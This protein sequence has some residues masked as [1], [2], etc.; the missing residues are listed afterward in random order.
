MQ[1]SFRVFLTC[2]LVAAGLLILGC[3]SAVNSEENGTEGEND[4]VSS[5]L[6]NLEGS[7]RLVASVPGH[8]ARVNDGFALYY[9]EDS[10]NKSILH[11]CT[12]SDGDGTADTYNREENTLKNAKIN[13]SDNLITF[14]TI[15]VAKGI[16]YTDENLGKEIETEYFD[17]RGEGGIFDV[18]STPQSG[19]LGMA[20]TE[21]TSGVPTSDADCQ[22]LDSFISSNRDTPSRRDMATT[23]RLNSSSSGF[24]ANNSDSY[25]LFYDI[26]SD[27]TILHSCT[28]SD[29]DDQADTYVKE[30]LSV[31]STTTNSAGNAVV[32]ETIEEGN[33]VVYDS[34]NEGGETT[35]EYLGLEGRG[36]LWWVQ[37]SSQTDMTGNVY[38]VERTSGVPT[39]DT[40]CDNRDQFIQ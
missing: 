11:T 14:R 17:T 35:V 13:D 32:T 2:S 36:A 21:S 3:D 23:W 30:R 18:V 24:D 34:E 29:G 12:D 26:K 7:T 6:E 27:E 28:D 1:F 40:E 22:D 39:S 16:I 33:G 4:D 31:K 10:D 8:V 5:R 25:A 20:L 19:N 37:G 15:E 38:G 9:E